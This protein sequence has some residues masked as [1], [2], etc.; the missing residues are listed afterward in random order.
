MRPLQ[1]ALLAELPRLSLAPFLLELSSPGDVTLAPRV[2]STFDKT[3]SIC[4]FLYSHG[5]ENCAI[6]FGRKSWIETF[7]PE[8]FLRRESCGSF[9]FTSSTDLY[10]FTWTNGQTEAWLLLDSVSKRCVR[11]FLSELSCQILRWVRASCVIQR[12]VRASFQ[13][14]RWVEA[15]LSDSEVGGSFFVRFWGGWELFCQI[16]RWVGAF[17]SDSEVGESFWSDSEV[18]GSFF[19]RFRG[20]W[21]LFC[22]IQR[23]VEAYIRVGRHPNGLPILIISWCLRQ[24]HQ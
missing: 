17:L 13:I 2:P 12:W 18:G 1:P 7:F 5:Y 3:H 10:V 21:K 20:G 23:W 14:Q 11:A 9:P 19:V 22:Q 6:F 16:L 24:S 8:P 15:F 4:G